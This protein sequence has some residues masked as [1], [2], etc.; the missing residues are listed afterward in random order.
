[1]FLRLTLLLPL[2]ARTLAAAMPATP[3][4]SN[5][6]S[7]NGI[8]PVFPILPTG[9][10][11]YQCVS[12]GSW[13]RPDVNWQTGCPRAWG[14]AR[15]TEMYQTSKKFEFLAHGDQPRYSR[16]RE[17]MRTPR[18][19]SVGEFDH[20]LKIQHSSRPC[21]RLVRGYGG[22][23]HETYVLLPNMNITRRL[24]RRHRQPRRL[25]R[26]RR[27]PPRPTPQPSTRSVRRHH[28]Q[29]HLARRSIRL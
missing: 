20:M 12:L 23:G 9:L 2:S 24:H 10:P 3:M 6:S 8:F 22:E 15:N 13:S 16:W 27:R 1:M 11:E 4:L 26:K 7:L 5:L 14:L 28:L 21:M 17:E 18:R 25:P 29:R 19:Y